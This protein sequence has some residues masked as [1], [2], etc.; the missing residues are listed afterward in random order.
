MATSRLL[1]A[2]TTSGKCMFS[3]MAV[4]IEHQHRLEQELVA[5]RAPYTVFAVGK[6]WV[7][8]HYSGRPSFKET[9]YSEAIARA[10]VERRVL[11]HEHMPIE[12]EL[13]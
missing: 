2:V 5:G 13:L 1:S 9:A 11:G 12:L 4:N 6:G 10:T 8:V 3:Q 7:F